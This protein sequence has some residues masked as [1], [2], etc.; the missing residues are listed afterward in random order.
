MG[1]TTLDVTRYNGI[2]VSRAGGSCTN[3]LRHLAYMGWDCTMCHMDGND[4]GNDS[5]PPPIEAMPTRFDPDQ[6]KYNKHFDN[7]F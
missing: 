5:G 7:I 6:I 3:I 2:E 1:V 4:K